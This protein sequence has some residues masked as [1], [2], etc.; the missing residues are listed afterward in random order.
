ML[1]MP[2]IDYGMKPNPNIFNLDTISDANAGLCR[3]LMQNFASQ[4]MKYLDSLG[5]RVRL[6]AAQ[7][8]VFPELRPAI[9]CDGNKWPE[10]FYLKG[11][12]RDARAQEEA[13][14]LPL[15]GAL[16]EMRGDAVLF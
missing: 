15:R 11:R 2:Y 10:Y 14:A 5:S 12:S 1:N 7:P 4:V 8:S 9:D 6:F 16:A 13:V 3:V